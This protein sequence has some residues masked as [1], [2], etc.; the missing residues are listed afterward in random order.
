MQKLRIRY[1]S[2]FGKKLLDKTLESIDREA[3]TNI[4]YNKFWSFLQLVLENNQETKIKTQ[5]KI[6]VCELENYNEEALVNLHYRLLCQIDNIKIFV[7]EENNVK[8]L[9]LLENNKMWDLSEWGED[10]QLKIKIAVETFFMTLN[11]NLQIDADE[12]NILLV[13]YKFFEHN[14]QEIKEAKTTIYLHLVQNLID[15]GLL[16]KEE[17]EIVKKIINSLD[18]SPLEKKE[19][20]LK[21]FNYYVKTLTHN[22][23]ITPQK[24]KLSKQ[25]IEKI[26]HIGN[27]MN[28]DS[29]YINQKISEITK[30]CNISNY[31]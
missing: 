2:D 11:D 20:D 12:I 29:N 7:K 25:I 17:D 22:P 5:N 30:S 8:Y 3:K 27:K 31:S 24:S 10:T 9:A 19:L 16:S 13:I 28:I 15:D 4:L 18:I 26:K 14:I 21:A 6:K 1:I 23:T